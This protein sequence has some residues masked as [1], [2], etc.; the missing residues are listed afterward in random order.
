MDQYDNNGGMDPRKQPHGFLALVL[1]GA[2]LLGGGFLT[3][4]IL[5]GMSPIQNTHPDASSAE[6]IVLDEPEQTTQS[7]SDIY[8]TELIMNSDFSSGSLMLVNNDYIYA[9]T[10]SDVVSI[11]EYKTD[12][13][14]VKDMDVL[15]R[16][17][18]VE[19]LNN[20]L[21]AF[22]THSGLDDILAVSGYRTYEYQKSLYDADLA[23]NGSDSSSYVAKPGYSEHQTGYALDI[24]IYQDG[25]SEDFDGTGDYAWILENCAKYGFILRYPEDKTEL[26]GI[27]YEPWHLRYVGAPHA[28]YIAEQGL[29]LEEYITLLRDYPYGETHLEITDY[30]GQRYEVYYVEMDLLGDATPVPVPS[31]LSYTVSGNNADGFIVT[32]LLEEGGSASQPEGTNSET[33]PEETEASAEPAETEE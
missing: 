10:D 28:C 16:K 8:V 30:G 18:A 14:A 22:Q 29:C 24:S 19:A 20:L 1:A 7:G 25:I 4:E 27:A 32:V 23:E 33:E 9:G 11:Y 2:V 17:P 5:D 15:L 13:Y 6:D 21:D 26:T 31:E 3:K 12:S